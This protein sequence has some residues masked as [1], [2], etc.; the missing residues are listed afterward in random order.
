M[1][2]SLDS[3]EVNIPGVSRRGKVQVGSHGRQ[4]LIF[5]NKVIVSIIMRLKSQS[6]D[7]YI[8]LINP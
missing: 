5:C 1:I 4:M 6:R 2:L 8:F 7:N 3:Y